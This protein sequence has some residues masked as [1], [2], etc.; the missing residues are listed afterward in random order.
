MIKQGYVLKIETDLFQQ[1]FVWNGWYQNCKCVS[2]WS[3][4]SA[5]ARHLF[6]RPDLARKPNL[7][8]E[9][10][11]AQLWVSK[12]AVCGCSCRYTILSHPK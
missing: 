2:F 3:P 7:P 4:N 1:D 8:S 6:L 11:Y 5:R 9:S 10:R 12:S